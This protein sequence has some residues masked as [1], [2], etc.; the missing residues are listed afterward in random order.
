MGKIDTSRLA[1]ALAIIGVIFFAD[2]LT[3][4]LILSN[5][6]FNALEC[7]RR[8][9]PCGKIELSNVVDLSMVWNFGFSFG[10]AQSE[11][12]GRW[13]LVFIQFAVSILFFAWLLQAKF[14]LTALS[15]AMVIGGGI[16]NVVDRIRFG[17][18]VE[19]IDFSGPWFGIEFPLPDFAKGVEGIFTSPAAQDGMLGLG[20]PY[21]F[22]I[23]DTAI[24]VGA[25]LLLIDQ[26]LL[27]RHGDSAGS[28]EKT[29]LNK[30]ANEN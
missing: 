18:V 22:N 15:L 1:W 4:Y 3:K 17:A 2:Q 14:R 29:T 23:A 25:I 10:M 16:G 7:L 9:G 27:K 28:P 24:T 5:D 26:F 20:F 21:V 13:I 12:I 19:F 11:G 8:T 30:A 6:T